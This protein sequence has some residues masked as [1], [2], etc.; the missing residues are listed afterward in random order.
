MRF[1]WTQFSVWAMW[2]TGRDWKRWLWF[3]NLH[4]HPKIGGKC[5]TEKKTK[6]WFHS[7][8]LSLSLFLLA[9]VGAWLCTCTY[10]HTYTYTCV[11][12][13]EGRLS[14]PPPHP[15]S[16]LCLCSRKFDVPLR[17]EDAD[18]TNDMDGQFGELG[19]TPATSRF[20]SVGRRFP[21]DGPI[22]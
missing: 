6:T 19:S 18:T 15:A 17:N 20:L 13:Y 8:S 7:V 2:L 11:P 10:V 14:V 1:G 12:T 21:G 16:T 4:L 9:C 3:G 22:F 5:K